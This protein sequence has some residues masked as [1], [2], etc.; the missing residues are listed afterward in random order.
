MKFNRFPVTLLIGASMALLST[1]AD[2]KRIKNM[3]NPDFTKG[4]KIPEGAVHDWTLGATGAR[5]WMYTDKMSTG[6]ARQIFITEVA[7]GSPADGTLKK[8]DVI[9]GI[10]TKPF[11][12][13]ARITF[14][15]A[16]TA[17][18]SDAGAGKL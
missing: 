8:G 3:P 6:K 16:L 1:P 18:E 7:K 11:D 13:D 10:G 5:G 17:A 15:K 2:A 14:G 9:L 4:E 12:S